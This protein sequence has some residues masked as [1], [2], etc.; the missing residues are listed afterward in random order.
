[1]VATLNGRF[2]W[3]APEEAAGHEAT[4]PA[5]RARALAWLYTAGP[6]LALL[7]LA[8]PNSPGTNELGILALVAAAYVAALVTV[9]WGPHLR[10]WVLSLL[11][12]FGTLLITGAIYFQGEDTGSYGYFY[13]WV[14][15]YAFYFESRG[16]AFGHLALIASAFA[17]IL[18]IDP[19]ANPIERWLITLGSLLIAGLLIRAL[20][21]NVSHL[22]ARLSDAARTD[23]LTDLLNRRGFEERFDLELARARRGGRPLSILLG[24]VDH[25]KKV[26]DRLGHEAGD[27]ALRRLSAVVEASRREIDT[28][29][30]I[31]GEEFALVLPETDEHGANRFAG[32]LRAAVRAAF[33]EQPVPLTI[34][35]GIATFPSHGKTRE[36][37]L[38]AGDQALYAAKGL[39][40][41]RST[42]H[43]AEV[44]LIVEGLESRESSDGEIH[45]TTAL[46]LAEALDVRISGTARHS[47]TVGRYAEMMARALGLPPAHVER[48]RLAGVLHDVGKIAVSDRILL[49]P[50]PWTAEER[51]QI[52]KHPEV[53]ARLLGSAS[54]NDIRA[55]VIAH[56]E[57]PDGSGYPYGLTGDVIPLE[58]KIVAVADAYEAMTADRVYRHALRTQAAREELRQCA[59]TQ[60]DEQVVE[61]F[62]DVLGDETVVAQEGAGVTPALR[63]L[64]PLAESSS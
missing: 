50:G 59:G 23:P 8:L 11:A 57:R 7:T 37:L 30:R 32:R 16:W 12:A 27:N 58:A 19:Q 24:D 44:S 15:L 63:S 22:M 29:A 18:L 34:S 36:S 46:T 21:D 47:Q 20:R 45:L 54:L 35:F 26:N 28:A 41:D 5:V 17:V 62:L 48:V 38:R 49:K 33:A 2:P 6:T 61:I 3:A 4:S 43:S 56:H 52:R 42:V 10:S 60:F 31:G 9:F 25:F 1:M 13:L 51:L 40:R 55:W 39:G 53:G 14:T 64:E